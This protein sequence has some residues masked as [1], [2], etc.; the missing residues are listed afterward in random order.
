MQRTL[1]ITISIFTKKGKIE[2]MIFL[3]FLS[4]ACPVCYLFYPS[5]FILLYFI[6]F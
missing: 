2:E 1:K 6:L 5:N 4:A 3:E